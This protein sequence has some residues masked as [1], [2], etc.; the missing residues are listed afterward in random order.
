MIRS[1]NTTRNGLASLVNLLDEVDE[2]SVKAVQTSILEKLLG[3][4]A[5]SAL[6]DEDVQFCFC[7][8]TSPEAA[9]DMLVQHGRTHGVPTGSRPR[10]AS[11]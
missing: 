2:A 5:A 10:L 11:Q 7:S 4:D 8:S 9:V 1:V 3:P 6:S